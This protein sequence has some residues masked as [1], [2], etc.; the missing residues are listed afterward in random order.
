ML[1]RQRRQL[2]LGRVGRRAAP[3][4]VLTEDLIVHIIDQI[5]RR[6][7][8]TLNGEADRVEDPTRNEHEGSPVARI[9]RSLICT[10]ISP[11]RTKTASSA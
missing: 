2:D 11:S 9:V 6:V 5:A 3:Q 7:P 4:S 8:A 1:G 10:V